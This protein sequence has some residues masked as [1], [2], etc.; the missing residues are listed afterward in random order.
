M[1]SGCNKY[2]KARKLTFPWVCDMKWVQIAS[3]SQTWRTSAYTRLNSQT[4]PMSLHY[5]RLHSASKSRGSS[6]EHCRAD[7]KTLIMVMF[8]MTR[9]SSST[10]LFGSLFPFFDALDSSL[11][12]ISTHLIPEYYSQHTRKHNQACIAVLFIH[13]PQWGTQDKIRSEEDGVHYQCRQ[14]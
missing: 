13:H 9:L 1:M 12:L 7:D 2:R 8:V 10:N 11:Q 6:L 14:E 4:P 5:Y 3:T